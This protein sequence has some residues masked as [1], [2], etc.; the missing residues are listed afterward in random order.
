MQPG[1]FFQ[2]LIQVAAAELKRIMGSETAAQ[3]LYGRGLARLRGVGS[4]FLGVDVA[5]FVDEVE[6]RRAG[7]RDRPVRIDL[8]LPGPRPP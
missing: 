1:R 4:P 3:A 8:A 7:A 2:G 5:R 6:A